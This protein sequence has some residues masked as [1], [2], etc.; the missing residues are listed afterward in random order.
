MEKVGTMDLQQ[1]TCSVS[2]QRNKQALAHFTAERALPYKRSRDPAEG[3]WPAGGRGSFLEQPAGDLEEG[4]SRAKSLLL[5]EVGRVGSAEG[6]PSEAVLPHSS[7]CSLFKRSHLGVKGY[8]PH[9]GKESESFVC[10]PPGPC[11]KRGSREL[12][13]GRSLTWRE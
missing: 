1:T 9:W 5:S 13:L 7:G 10:P 11:R 8:L 4:G 3:P 2:S 6:L 12:E